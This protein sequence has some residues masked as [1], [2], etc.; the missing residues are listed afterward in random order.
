MSEEL[1]TK[2]PDGHG[3]RIGNYEYYLLG[4]TT[5]KQLKKN[6]I[7]PNKD[8]KKYETRKPD[9]LLVDR[10]NKKKIKTICILEHKDDGKFKTEA[11]K[12][13]AI[14][15]CN[16]V[17][18]IL[19]AEIGIATDNNSY[20]WFNPKQKNKITEYEDRTT[21]AKRS[22]SIIIDTTDKPFTN[23]FAINQKTD[24]LDVKKLT[25]NTKQTLED[26]EKIRNILSPKNS[27]IVD[28]IQIDPTKLAKQIWQDVWSVSGATPEKCLYT[29]VELFIFKYLSDLNILTEDNSGNKVNFKDIFALDPAKAFMNYT[30]NVRP[31]LKEM[32]PPSTIDNTTI[33]NGT[34]L[35]PTVPEHSDAFY[36]ILKRFNTFGEMKNINPDFKSKVFEQFMK[37]SISKKNWGQYFTPR[38]IVDAMIKMSDIEKLDKDSKVCDPAC[39]VGG[40][41]LEPMKTLDDG[42][43]FYY[44]IT[45][46]KIIPRLEFS[47]FDK[48]FEKEEQLTIILAKANMLIFLSELL[49]KNDA[50]A[51]EF[52]NLFN[53]T[54]NLITNTI[55]G[56]L[57]QTEYDKYD[58]ILTNPPYVTS[59]SSNYKTAIKNN[60]TLKKFY[61]INA[62][63]VESLFLEWIINSLK[64]DKKAFVI[65]P[66]GILNR[67]ES[68]LR[69]FVRDECIIDGIISL[70]INAFY[71][72]PKKTYILCITKKPNE[73]H[74]ERHKNEQTTPVFTYLVSDIG[75][76][77]D[78]N[79]FQIDENDL[80]TMVPLFNQFKGIRSTFPTDDKRCKIQP[81]EKF[82]PEQHW[83]VDRWWSKDEKI[84]LGIEE[85]ETVLTLEEF[86]EK[87]QEVAT[88]I[89]ELTK[90]L[91]QFQ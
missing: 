60:A 54:M 8:Y 42:V 41:I 1:N 55:L 10:R 62:L 13:N 67:N 20:I 16:D 21:K 22:Y 12:K 29:F 43:N 34:V 80:E 51:K 72:T 27:K 74:D 14:E 39:G 24:E 65:I 66:D 89:N 75:E 68:K 77:L 84:E 71:T 48:G 15:E 49:K 23:K 85:E 37:E 5:L 83:A 32:F 45:G 36:K 63:G 44:K 57:A 58:L 35:N 76:T 26:V 73:S 3:L 2:Y 19:N 25:S 52:S 38:N 46:N 40:F 11:D 88:K 31:Y 9:G 28:D 30:K 69:A 47:G 90:E 18:Q 91:G 56:T 53:S 70:P 81:I 33:I 61:K 7:I 79:R 87:T 4:N 50:M 17:C 64:P 78:V 82:D 86:V 59:G 6:K